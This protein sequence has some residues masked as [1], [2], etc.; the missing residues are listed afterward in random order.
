VLPCL[1]EVV[2]NWVRDK[3]PASKCE[4]LRHHRQ[5]YLH[6]KPKV[7]CIIRLED[8]CWRI[9]KG[10]AIFSTRYGSSDRLSSTALTLVQQNLN[11][12]TQT[13]AKTAPVQRPAVLARPAI[14]FNHAVQVVVSAGP[15]LT[16]HLDSAFM[17]IHPAPVWPIARIALNVAQAKFLL[18][19][20]TIVEV[21]VLAQEVVVGQTRRDR[22]RDPE[23]Y[24]DLS[25][26]RM[27]CSLEDG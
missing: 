4:G 13:S 24:H 19:I 21:F 6:I 15:S 26:R 25:L 5:L 18:R 9:R 27:R 10:A 17:G 12:A 3:F 23:R 20:L 8:H 11:S 16:V 1:S 2:C 14:H 7:Q 22:Y